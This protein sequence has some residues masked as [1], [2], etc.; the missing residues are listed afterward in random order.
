VVGEKRRQ[1]RLRIDLFQLRQGLIGHGRAALRA[2]LS[3]ARGPT[4]YMP[5]GYPWACNRGTADRSRARSVH[6]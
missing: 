4:R 6:Q 1:Q 3:R 2:I 5:W